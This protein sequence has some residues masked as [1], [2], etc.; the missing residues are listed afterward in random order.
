MKMQWCL[1]VSWWSMPQTVWNIQVFRGRSWLKAQF[2]SSYV[3]HIMA[4][5][6]S[7][8]ELLGHVRKILD[9]QT[10]TLLYK[11]LILPIYEYCDWI[12]FPTRLGSADCLQELQNCT[13]RS[14]L[15]AYPWTHTDILDTQV[16]VRRLDDRHKLHVIEQVHKVVNRR[17][18]EACNNL[19]SVK[20]HE[21]K[22]GQIKWI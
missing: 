13:L 22:G 20:Q 2:S 3:D 11:T 17:G 21:T 16:Q 6:I 18:P 19:C 9:Q 12:Y 8:I 10:A 1:C 15:Q 7:K 5:T 14:I 4:K